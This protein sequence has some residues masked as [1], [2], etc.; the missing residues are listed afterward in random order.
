MARR[1]QTLPPVYHTLLDGTTMNQAEFDEWKKT[2][3]I[4]HTCPV[5][6][7]LRQLAK[8]KANA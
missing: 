2:H 6:D 4:P 8:E 1:A 5:Y 3:V 7:V